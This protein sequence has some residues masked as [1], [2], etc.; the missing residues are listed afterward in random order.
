MHFEKYK[1]IAL[2]TAEEAGR[3]L[4]D[5]QGRTQIHFKGET[6]LV[7]EA[8]L[9]SERLCQ[10]R[11]LG[12]FPGTDYLG[13]EGAARR[14][15]SEFM[16]VVDP[17]DGTNNYAHGIPIFSVSIGLRYQGEVILGVVHAPAMQETYIAAKGAGATLN[18]E[19]IRVSDIRELRK[20]IL[21]TGFPYDKRENPQNNLDHFANLTLEAQG[22]RRY[23][24]ASID[25]CWVAAGRFDGYWE[26]RLGS[27]DVDAGSLVVRE[28]GGLVTDFAG[29]P[30]TDP[31]AHIL[32]SNGWIHE[33]MKEVLGVLSSG[34]RPDFSIRRK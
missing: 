2:A 21:A 32:A 7:T 9:E 30:A 19:P 22:I 27:W 13:E 4:L 14:S 23:G 25:L 16:W 34:S 33:Q 15:G 1:D 12:A 10:D 26:M 6:N 3:L 8:D 20:S 24:C 5:R 18:N 31:P 11:L 28:A 29:G 17:I